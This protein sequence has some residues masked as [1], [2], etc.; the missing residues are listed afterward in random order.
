MHP[1]LRLTGPLLAVALML[2]SLSA[3]AAVAEEND[4]KKQL[5]ATASANGT[6]YGFGRLC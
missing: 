3:S 5:I 1:T 6:L 4:D 2:C